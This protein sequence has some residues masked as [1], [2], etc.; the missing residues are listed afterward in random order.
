[1]EGFFETTGWTPTVRKMVAGAVTYTRYSWLKR[2]V[3]RRI[4]RGAYGQT[5]ASR[6]YEYTDWNDVRDF[7]RM[8]IRLVFSSAGPPAPRLARAARGAPSA[9]AAH[10]RTRSAL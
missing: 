8:F 1:M 6:D 7:T 4:V 9:H 2:L 5:D 10:A 3:V